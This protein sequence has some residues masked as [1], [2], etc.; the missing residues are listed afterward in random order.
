MMLR[1]CFVEMLRFLTIVNTSSP[2][3]YNI[4]SHHHTIS[5]SQPFNFLYSVCL[6]IP[7]SSAAL[8]MLP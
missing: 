6:V 5:P 2:H 1:C 3:H 8:L 4:I 7:S